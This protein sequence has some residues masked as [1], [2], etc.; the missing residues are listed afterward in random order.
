MRRYQVYQADTVRGIW[1]CQ[2]S[3]DDVQPVTCQLTTRCILRNVTDSNA[4]V[5]RPDTAPDDR[6]TPF[7]KP[8][9]GFS[10]VRRI[11]LLVRFES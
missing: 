2:R 10:A 8:V 9:V 1:Q 4:L 11:F 7:S 3:A 6:I 5:L